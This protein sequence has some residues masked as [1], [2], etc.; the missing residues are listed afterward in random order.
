MA[1]GERKA[2]PSL[3]YRKKKRRER[4]RESFSCCDYEKEEGKRERGRAAARVSP[5]TSS[6]FGDGGG[7]KERGEGAKPANSARGEM[8]YYEEILGG[9]EEREGKQRLPLKRTV[10]PLAFLEK[11]KKKEGS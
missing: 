11:K 7:E 1:K 2:R 10:L 6:S 5:F 9:E 8:L 4:S 3:S